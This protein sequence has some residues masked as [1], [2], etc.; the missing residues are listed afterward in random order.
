MRF[1]PK[2]LEFLSA[3]AREEK[4][5]NPY[6]LPAHEQQAIHHVRGVTLIRAI[7]A[8]ARAEGQSDEEI[9]G[10]FVNPNPVWPWSSEEELN[11]RIGVGLNLQDVGASGYSGKRTP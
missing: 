2:E 1:T 5:A 9:C 7:K 4:A 8:W 6:V 3:W 11:H 10:L